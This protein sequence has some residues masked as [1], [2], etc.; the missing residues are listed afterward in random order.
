M[1]AGAKYHAFLMPGNIVGKKPYWLRIMLPLKKYPK[2]CGNT[3][4]KTQGRSKK[5]ITKIKALEKD[6][7]FAAGG[8]QVLAW[9][10]FHQCL[11]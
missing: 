7:P 11:P 8:V 5:K 9:K 3:M 10:P 4:Q 1:M 6:V 2:K